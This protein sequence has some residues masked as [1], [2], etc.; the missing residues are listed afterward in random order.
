MRGHIQLE[1]IIRALC[2]HDRVPSWS[3][4]KKSWRIG[5]G[6]CG[7]SEKSQNA[8]FALTEF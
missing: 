4:H 5:P 6:L 8:N 3:L 1:G 7:T 2:I